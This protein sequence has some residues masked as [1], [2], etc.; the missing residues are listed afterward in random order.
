M[1]QKALDFALFAHL[2]QLRKSGDSYIEHP[3]SVAENLWN[4]FHDMNLTIGG[5]LHDTVE[6]N[7]AISLEQIEQEFG[8][9]VAFLVDANSKNRQNFLHFPEINIEDKIE[10]ILWASILDIRTILIKIADRHH[11]ISTISHLKENRQVRMSFETQA[12]F[13]PL[14]EILGFEEGRSIQECQQCLDNYMKKN[15]ITTPKSLKNALISCF[16]T[17]I[18]NYSYNYL[19]EYSDKILWEVQ[20]LEVFIDLCKDSALHRAISLDSIVT[21]QGIV[22]VLFKLKHAGLLPKDASSISFYTFSS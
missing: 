5:L 22:S 10:R 3:I 19:Y 20:G 6:D 12:I 8:K 16:F 1:L 7:P 11:N 18:D 21:R 4:K 2:G 9:E 14:V 13:Y 15:K 17:N